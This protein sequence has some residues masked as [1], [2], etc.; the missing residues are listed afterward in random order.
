MYETPNELSWMS[1]HSTS[2]N[3]NKFASLIFNPT[4]TV[5][6]ANVDTP[7]NLQILK[8]VSLNKRCALYFDPGLTRVIAFD[9][10]SKAWND[11]RNIINSTLLTGIDLSTAKFDVGNDCFS[12]RINDKVLHTDP[13]TRIFTL[14]SLPASLTTLLSPGF[15]A[16]FSLMVTND[17][18][19]VFVPKNSTTPSGQYVLSRNDSFYSLKNVLRFGNYF[20]VFSQQ[21]S[22]TPG[23]WNFKLQ[24]N[25][26]SGTTSK[27]IAEF[28]NQTTGKA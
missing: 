7:A 16:D 2:A 23:K 19:S 10:V 5:Q 21:E 13:S 25:L 28:A 26:L 27:K 18:L 11:T 9:L 8:A 15:S 1:S 24:F 6:T 22:S 20:V 17:A 12:A 4:E 14:D 3:K